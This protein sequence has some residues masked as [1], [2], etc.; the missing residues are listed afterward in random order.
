MEFR[1]DPLKNVLTRAKT[2]ENP[3]THTTKIGHLVPV[4]GFRNMVPDVESISD[5]SVKFGEIR[6]Q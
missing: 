2:S 3:N 1:A 4:Y 6:N 5:L